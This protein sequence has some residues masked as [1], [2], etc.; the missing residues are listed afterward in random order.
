MSFYIFFVFCDEIQVFRLSPTVL[1]KDVA[2][3]GALTLENGI[4]SVCYAHLFF[5]FDCFFIN[6][7]K[8][9]NVF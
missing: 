6:D 7:D 4:D 8:V 2:S 1:D 9:V 5:V 3:E